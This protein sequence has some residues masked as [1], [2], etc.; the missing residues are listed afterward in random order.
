MRGN[1]NERGEC[2]SE[3]EGCAP[4]TTESRQGID[5][6][7]IAWVERVILTLVIDGEG[8]VRKSRGLREGEGYRGRR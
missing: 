3:W 7:K 1:I 8:G 5:R 2:H 6:V 4:I